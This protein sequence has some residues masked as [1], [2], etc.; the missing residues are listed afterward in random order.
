[1]KTRRFA[2]LEQ[3]S[4]S[5]AEFLRERQLVE[6]DYSGAEDKSRKRI[7]DSGLVQMMLDTCTTIN[8]MVG[9]TIVDVHSF[10]PPIPIL[11]CFIYAEGGSEYF[12]RLEL[13][14]ATPTL[15]FAERSCRDTVANDFDSS[16][17]RLANIEPVTINVKL[18]HEF[19]DVCVSVEEVREW[20]KYLVS[21]LDRSSHT[22]I[23]ITTRGS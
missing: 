16:I 1:M 8:N 12:L 21:R 19:Q 13:Q 6:T 15:I 9:R 14:G 10:L 22:V 4:A 3:G 11:C 23:L 5:L 2:I 7:E 18:V 20:F 17:H